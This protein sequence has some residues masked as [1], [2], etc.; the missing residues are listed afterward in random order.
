MV[1]QTGPWL[2]YLYIT[3]KDNETDQAK[4]KIIKCMEEV[5]FWMRSNYLKL[6]EDKTVIKLFTHKTSTVSD[7]HVIGQ[8]TRGPIKILGILLNDATKFTEFITRKTQTCNYHLR[9][10]YNI[11]DS[12]DTKT[13]MSHS[14]N[15]KFNFIYY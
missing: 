4:P 1:N 13:R 10:L 5:K 3:F 15:H 9:N 11:R 8:T 12:L 6:N 14:I 7:F 2:S